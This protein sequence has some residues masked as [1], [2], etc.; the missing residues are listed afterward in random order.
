MPFARIDLLKG[1][2]AE[3]RATVADI[4]YQGI[5]GVLKAPDGDRFIVIDEHSPD[6]LI[7]DP[8]FLGWDRSADFILIQVTSTV[9]N[10]KD[11]K[12]AFFRYI[13]D[14]L[15]SKLSV[16]P[17]DIMISMVFV[18]RSDWSFGNGEPWV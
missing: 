16:R 2:T 5:V 4:V 13:A 10:N 15:K 17:D 11:S 14:E 12:L 1:K 8:K 3:Y 18:D 9:G 6:N 7:Y